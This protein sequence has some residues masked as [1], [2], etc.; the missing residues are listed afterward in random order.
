M[1]NQ[2]NVNNPAIK[3]IRSIESK[4]IKANININNSLDLFQEFHWILVYIDQDNLHSKVNIMYK[5]NYGE[6]HVH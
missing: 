5:R 4:S 6:V 1:I 2:R 3:G